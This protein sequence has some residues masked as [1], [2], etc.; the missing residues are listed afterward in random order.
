MRVS[1]L[2]RVMVVQMRFK[3]IT[4]WFECLLQT[5]HFTVLVE[6]HCRR[7]VGEEEDGVRTCCG[8]GL[9]EDFEEED[10]WEALLIEGEDF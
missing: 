3:C 6:A 4:L 2:L 8:K 9:G 5:G 7:K 10:F 1:A